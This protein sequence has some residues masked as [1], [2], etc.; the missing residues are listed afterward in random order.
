MECAAGRA[1]AVTS[2]RFAKAR[3]V[4]F[5]GSNTAFVPLANFAQ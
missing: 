5:E 1:S 4:T 2:R 3:C